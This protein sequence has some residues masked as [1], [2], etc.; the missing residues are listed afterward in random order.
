MDFE[1]SIYEHKVL[2]IG[3]EAQGISNEARDFQ[4]QHGATIRIPLVDKVNSLN[5]ATA[6]SVVLFE[7]RRKLNLIKNASKE[8]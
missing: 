2:V 6:L 1:K 5:V 8:E 4:K 3:G 7:M